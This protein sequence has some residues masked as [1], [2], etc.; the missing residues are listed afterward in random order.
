[1]DRYEMNR[2]VTFAAPALADER[3]TGFLRAVYGWMFA[4]LAVTALVAYLVAGSR[5]S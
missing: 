4:G 2:D 3:I 1:M 5:R